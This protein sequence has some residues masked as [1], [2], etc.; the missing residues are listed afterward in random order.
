MSS[1]RKGALG[2]AMVAATLTGGV[3]GASL[4]G[5]ASA[6]TPAPTTTTTAPA[7]GGASASGGD[8]SNTDPAHEAAESPQREAD[9][10]AGKLGG[11][12]RGHS[13]T[14]PAHEAAES[15]A[16][17]AQEAAADAAQATT[18]TTP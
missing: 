1:L 11:G 7:T 14:D 12:H 3:I 13:N 4:V 2:A 8:H 15:P 9:E 16:R 17:A 6:Q 5:S 18:T 10:T